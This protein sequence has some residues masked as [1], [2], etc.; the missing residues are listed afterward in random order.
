MGPLLF[1]RYEHLELIGKG[2]VAEVYRAEHPAQNRAVA[3]KVLLS[4]L[5]GDDIWA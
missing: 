4:N 2:G 5:A 1:S 3:I